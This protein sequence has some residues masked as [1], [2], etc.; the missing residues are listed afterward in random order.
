MLKTKEEA[1]ELEDHLSLYARPT[2]YYTQD[3]ELGEKIEKEVAELL[4]S[5]EVRTLDDLSP[6]VR[7][8]LEI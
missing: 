7:E 6:D 1:Y 2:I 4:A 8:A 5:P 3:F